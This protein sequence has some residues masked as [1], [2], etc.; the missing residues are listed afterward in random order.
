AETLSARNGRIVTMLDHVAK[1]AGGGF[2]LL[3]NPFLLLEVAP[4]ETAQDVIRAFDQAVRDASCD[5]E[6]L[7]RAREVLLTPALRTD[8]EVGGLLGVSWTDA[9]RLHAQLIAGLT[10]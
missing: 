2:N 9:A 10:V 7:Q 1:T 5:P 4:A 6:L 8:A 3:L